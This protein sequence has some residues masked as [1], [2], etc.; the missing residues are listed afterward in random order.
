MFFSRAFWV[1]SIVVWIITYVRM[2]VIILDF[3]GWL[4]GAGAY[5]GRTFFEPDRFLEDPNPNPAAYYR[6]MVTSPTCKGLKAWMSD[7]Q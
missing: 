2:E 5:V 7:S 4:A 3:H 6:V 1:N